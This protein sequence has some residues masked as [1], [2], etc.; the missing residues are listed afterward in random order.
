[1]RLLSLPTALLSTLAILA[2]AQL[3]LDTSSSQSIKSVARDISKS[4]VKIY[5]DRLA[6]PGW[7]I[8]GLLPPPY[9]WWEFGGMFGVLLGYWHVTGDD[10]PV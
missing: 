7:D 3:A 6:I 9:Y 1:M 8:P 4:L 10:Q 5:T 2:S